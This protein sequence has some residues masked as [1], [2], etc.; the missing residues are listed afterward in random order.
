MSGE[1]GRTIC[2]DLSQ[3]GRSHYV[4]AKHRRKLRSLASSPSLK[5][6]WMQ[7][8]AGDKLQRTC[9]TDGCI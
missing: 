4:P 3:E 9:F 2:D 7:S 1:S 5:L 8:N 6:S